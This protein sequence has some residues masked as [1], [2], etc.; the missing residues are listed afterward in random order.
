MTLVAM[1]D[2]KNN[3]VWV[4]WSAMVTVQALIWCLR[5]CFSRNRN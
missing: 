1:N 4:S 2:D 5:E 3:D